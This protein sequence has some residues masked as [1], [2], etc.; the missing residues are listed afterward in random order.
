MAVLH[1][2]VTAPP[3]L[4]SNCGHIAEEGGK[5]RSLISQEQNGI[6][7]VLI[8]RGPPRQAAAYT[9]AAVR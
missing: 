7:A 8:I 9:C 3:L 2:E 6:V 4:T 5:S 1:F